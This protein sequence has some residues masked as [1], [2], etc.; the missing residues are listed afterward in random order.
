VDS[1]IGAY[2]QRAVELVRGQSKIRA[3]QGM[4]YRPRMRSTYLALVLLLCACPAASN[5]TSRDGST[6][7]SL[8]LPD[9]DAGAAAE[10]EQALAS[11]PAEMKPM[12]AAAALA[13]L[14]QA[15]LPSSFLA[16]L[17]AMA[18]VA[19]DMRAP[20]LAKAIGE[21][22]AMLDHLCGGKGE[23]IAMMRRLA[24]AV[25]ERRSAIIYD[26][27]GLEGRGYVERGQLPGVDGMVMLMAHL[28]DDHLRRGGELHAGE[29]AAIMA[30][31]GAR[32]GS[33]G[34]GAAG[35]DVD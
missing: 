19:P 24:D 23:G 34:R 25:W 21:N 27:C 16:G 15:R 26:S 12:F 30:M 28:V 20:M 3:G 14:E 18:N 32:V 2:H 9:V 22:M 6:A 7:G 33:R 1:R 11:A 29:R 10:L 17:D 5:S 35:S 8:E 13:E 4:P 31:A